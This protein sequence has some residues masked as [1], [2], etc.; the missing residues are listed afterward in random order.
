MKLPRAAYPLTVGGLAALTLLSS[1][2]AAQAAWTAGGAG[3][4]GQAAARALPTAGT[5]A[6]TA[7]GSRVELSWPP[8]LVAPGVPADGYQVTRYDAV[9]AAAAGVLAGCAGTVA[10]LRCTETG[11][12]D[13][14]WR[15]A[16]R[17]V[18]G[19]RWTGPYGARSVPVTVAAAP[20][21]VAVTFPVA[22]RSY[23][24]S[25]YQAGC[26]TGAGDLCGT[27]TAGSGQ[28]TAVRVSVRRG[29]GNYWDPATSGFT[30]A[31]EK[32]FDVSS[33]VA[34]WKVTFPV[35]NFP[36]GGAYTVRAVATDDTGGTAATASSFTVDPTPPAAVDVQATN[37][38]AGTVG[39]IGAGDVLALS[40]SEPVDPAS[41]SAGWTGAATPVVVRVNRGNGQAA[42]DDLTVADATGTTALAPLGV[43]SLGRRGYV[44]QDVTFQATM[45]LDGSTIRIT[46]GTVSNA[47]RVT[48]VS[49]AAA[50]RW[51]VGTAT[52][53]A[54]NPLSNA[55]AAITESGPADVEF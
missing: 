2:L 55:G 28:L 26:D 7:D 49:G 15:Y 43:I 47:N 25:G 10:A 20:P 17:A 19:T 37:G 12:P 54:G 21:T 23:G 27:A 30:S 51:T 39:L 16:V 48:Q 5:P 35:E 29:V 33:G 4:R 18:H 3:A 14:Q 24:L 22:G 31:A 52:D 13:G 36:A 38:S 11:V 53:P 44:S 46:L 50:M 1:T 41:I 42:T 40:Y 9:S 8:A 32:L 34:A 45:V 6:A